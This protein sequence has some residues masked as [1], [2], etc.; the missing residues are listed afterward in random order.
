MC[1]VEAHLKRV[2]GGGGVIHKGGVGVLGG[3]GGAWGAV[4]WVGVEWLPCQ[5]NPPPAPARHS[6]RTNVSPSP[7]RGRMHPHTPCVPGLVGSLTNIRRSARAPPEH[8]LSGLS[9]PPPKHT[10]A[11]SEGSCGCPCGTCCSFSRRPP[12]LSGGNMRDSVRAGRESTTRANGTGARHE[13][14]RRHR[15]EQGCP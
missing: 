15:T 6:L 7:T 8:C 11:H 14:Q 5:P 4:L 2:G 10:K 9:T 1:F 13:N 3:S 12:V